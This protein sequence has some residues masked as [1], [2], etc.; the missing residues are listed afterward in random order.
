MKAKSLQ[1]GKAM[2]AALFVLLLSVA[3]MKNALAQTQVATLQHGDD[4]SVFYGSNALYQAHNA[5]EHGDVITLSSGS[6]TL[7]GITK[8]VTIRGAGCVTDT[9]AHI[10]PTIIASNVYSNI[11]YSD[12]VCLIVEGVKF[13][14][15]FSINNGIVKSHFN[16]C[17]F[18]EFNVS[19][20]C[21]PLLQFLNCRIKTLRGNSILENGVFINSV[22]WHFTMNNSNSRYLAYNTYLR[23]VSSG[24]YTP[25]MSVYNC[26]IVGSADRKL[27]QSSVAVNCI[28]VNGALVSSYNDNCWD[29]NSIEDVF[30]TFTGDNIAYDT[31]ML[32]LK[33]EIANS[34]IGTDGTEVGINGGFV[35]YD[36]RPFYMFVKRCNV[37]NR[38]TIDGKLSVEIEVV[39]QE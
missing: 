11:P 16:K 23:L 28:G 32:I 6:F 22:I 9:I 38:S 19:I 31:E 21:Y 30:R 10:S 3:G 8:A 7:T 25:T 17:Y 2:S 35:P 12:T 4:I 1:F 26:I 27:S 36:A 24:P 20:N 37:A 13:T 18:S 29:Y 5:A 14:N 34:C 33:D 15:T 39:T